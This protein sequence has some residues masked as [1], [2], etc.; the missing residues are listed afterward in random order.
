MSNRRFFMPVSKAQRRWVV[1]VEESQQV[2]LTETSVF[3]DTSLQFDP[4]TARQMARTLLRAADMAERPP[5]SGEI[6]HS[7]IP[8]KL[9][10]IR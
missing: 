5:L 3:G 2:M 1:S 7:P 10:A 9:V 6:V 8:P 4:E